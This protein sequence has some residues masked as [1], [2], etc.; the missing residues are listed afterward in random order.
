MVFRREKEDVQILRLYMLL[1][2][3]A[4]WTES[5]NEL[6]CVISTKLAPH[7]ASRFAWKQNRGLFSSP[8]GTGR[9]N[10]ATLSVR[11]GMGT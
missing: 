10:D 7:F 2:R 5:Y 4:Y 6:G 1:L 8:L 9:A 11:Y 3:P